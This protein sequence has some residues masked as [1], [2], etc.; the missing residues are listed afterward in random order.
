M[1]PFL[2]AKYTKIIIFVVLING[3]V[4]FNLF[5]D[6]NK[7]LLF[8]SLSFQRDSHVKIPTLVLRILYRLT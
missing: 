2:L 1:L 5:N 8:F 7:P 6:H 3:G 4:K